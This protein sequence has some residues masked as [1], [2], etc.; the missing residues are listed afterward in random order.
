MLTDDFIEREDGRRSM[1]LGRV[2]RHIEV[3]LQLPPKSGFIMPEVILMFDLMRK[4]IQKAW[5]ES[6]KGMHRYIQRDGIIVRHNM[7]EGQ[8]WI[9]V[10]TFGIEERKSLRHFLRAYRDDFSP[11]TLVRLAINHSRRVIRMRLEDFERFL[12]DPT[13]GENDA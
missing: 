5:R 8:L 3:I 12:C 10:W 1:R 7:I 6:A 13:R 2:R 9:F 4:R 11:R